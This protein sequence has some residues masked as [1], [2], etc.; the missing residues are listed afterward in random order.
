MKMMDSIPQLTVDMEELDKQT[1]SASEHMIDELGDGLLELLI[2]IQESIEKYG[3]AV[4]T[5]K[6]E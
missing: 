1:K 3:V 5:E 4:I 2:S 6:K